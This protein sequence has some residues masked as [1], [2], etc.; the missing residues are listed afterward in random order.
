MSHQLHDPFEHNSWATGQLLDACDAVD[1]ALLDAKVPG[2]YGSVIETLRHIVDAE[3]GYLFRASGLWEEVPWTRGEPVG[4]AE[5]RSRADLLAET[6]R[7]Y[8]GGEVDS[9]RPNQA[10]SPEGDVFSVPTGIFLAQALHHANEHRAQI[11]TIL[12]ANG[13]EPPDVSAWG[14]ALA[15]GRMRPHAGA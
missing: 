9:E 3:A 6:W 1:P 12:G 4:L 5:L 10:R 8:L 15:T 14:F 11:C 2:A 7:Q 13:I